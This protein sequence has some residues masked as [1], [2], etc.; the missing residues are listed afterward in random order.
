[1]S[2]LENAI[3]QH[4][5]TFEGVTTSFGGR[6]SANGSTLETAILDHN[7]TI[8]GATLSRGFRNTSGSS[9][10]EQAILDHHHQTPLFLHIWRQRTCNT[11]SNCD[12]WQPWNG[13]WN[14]YFPMEWIPAIP[15]RSTSNINPNW[16]PNTNVPGDPTFAW[17][18]IRD[19]SRQIIGQVLIGGLS[20]TH[21]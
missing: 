17:I 7:H 10:L 14:P 1:M 3:L 13:G 11:D 5:H 6:M 20:Q 15:Y 9:T 8:S 19:L 21:R 12:L 16:M 18:E 2:T 4:R